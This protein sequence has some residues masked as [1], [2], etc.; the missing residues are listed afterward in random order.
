QKLPPE[1]R[2]RIHLLEV[3]ALA[4]SSTDV[5][6]RVRCGRSI[7]YLLPEAVEH[8]IYKNHLYVSDAEAEGVEEA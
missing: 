1:G 3:P 2:G 4:I 7:K 8:Y 6:E 5:R